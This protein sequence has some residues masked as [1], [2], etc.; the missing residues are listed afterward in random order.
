MPR[1][2]LVY[3]LF[4]SA[5]ATSVNTGGAAEGTKGREPPPPLS[6]PI[7]AGTLHQT[8]AEVDFDDMIEF[9]AERDI[10]YIGESHDQK[11]HHDIQLRVIEALHRLGR[12]DGIGMEMF[13]R[14]QQDALYKY[15]EGKIGEEEFLERSAFKTWGGY[16]LYMPILR[17]A[18]RH[19]LPVVALN[20]S[21]DVRKK[22]SKE[23]MEALP[24]EARKE[25]PVLYLDDA[26]HRVRLRAVYDQMQTQMQ[27]DHPK[28]DSF[29]RVMCLWD[30]V[31]ADTIVKWFRSQS[32]T[33]QIVVL[34]GTGHI[35][36]RNGIP[37]RVYRRNGKPYASLVCLAVDE[38]GPE[39]EV[40]S[41]RYADYV[42]VTEYVKP[43]KN[44]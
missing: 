30:D 27:P 35:G 44:K 24:F 33:A 1:L 6:K 36:H 40:F 23:G 16:E 42:W 28:F 10:V 8:A 3:L 18:R 31:M 5:C 12:L 38:E 4:L 21:T 19:R 32:K 11:E 15:V 37:G 17:Y 26:E 34:A 41:R 25:L 14:P 7:P 22:V 2:A 29:Y 9:L 13:Q 20:V 39:Q 43:A